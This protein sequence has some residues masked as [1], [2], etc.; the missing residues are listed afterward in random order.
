MQSYFERSKG[1]RNDIWM[2]KAVQAKLENPGI[3]LVG[4]LRARDRYLFQFTLGDSLKSRDSCVPP[5]RK[6]MP[7]GL[8]QKIMAYH[9]DVPEN[10]VYHVYLLNH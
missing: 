7:V 5:Q 8:T 6:C 10:H 4:S 3:S 1:D 2:T 9:G